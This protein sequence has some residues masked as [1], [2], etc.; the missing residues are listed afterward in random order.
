MLVTVMPSVE[1]LITLFGK[2]AWEIENFEGSKLGVDFAEKLR[3]L[4]EKL[5]KRLYRAA[6]IHEI[7]LKNGWKAKG[8]LYD[9][10]YS[11]PI[12]LEEAKE[13]LKRLGLESFIK[14]LVKSGEDYLIESC[15]PEIL[16]E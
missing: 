9:I 11:K 1:L 12:S 3:D 10:R 8:R 6:E 4:G 16:E 2:P 14:C 15:G 5:R 7:L 13:E